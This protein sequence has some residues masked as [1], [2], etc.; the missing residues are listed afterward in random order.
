MTAGVKDSRTLL[1]E[2]GLSPKKSFGQNFLVDARAV[3]SIARAA[4]PDSEVGRALVVE[5]GAGLGA[6]TAELVGR[7]RHVTA[8]ERDRDLVPVLA[9]SFAEAI[10]HGT[11]SVE[12]ADAK[13][14]DLEGLFAAARA[15]ETRVLCGNLPYQLTGPLLERSVQ[16]ASF[17]ERAIFMVQR[18]VAERLLAEPSTKEYGALTVFVRA[19]F[20]VRRVLAVGRGAFYPAP[21]VTS[22][23]VELSPCRPPRALETETFRALVKGAFGA[24]RKTLRNAWSALGAP[25]VARA[26]ESAGI[27][28]SARGETLDVT[29]F[30]RMSDALDGLGTDDTPPPP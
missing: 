19:A 4:V 10:E 26:A 3:Q 14:I 18:E 12:E 9:R 8:V 2:S 27:D 21:E 29:A 23:V 6:L 24:R 11:L 5:L 20:E 30:A 15:G 7:A 16:S 25:R 13:T 22:T 17:I 28:L 1:R